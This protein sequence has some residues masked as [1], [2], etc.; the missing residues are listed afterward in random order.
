MFLQI[1]TNITKI[2][3]HLINFCSEYRKWNLPNT[4]QDANHSTAM[5]GG[6]YLAYLK[7]LSQLHD[8]Q[9]GIT[10]NVLRIMENILYPV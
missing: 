1:L 7:T 9:S 5:F 10:S 6:C 3:S 4:K 2:L 8:S